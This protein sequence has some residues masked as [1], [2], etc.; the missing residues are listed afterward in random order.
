MWASWTQYLST[1]HVLLP[2][3]INQHYLGIA[4]GLP[5]YD[6][7]ARA[8]RVSLCPSTA[9]MTSRARR[10]HGST[11]A[12][13]QCVQRLNPR[14]AAC[15]CCRMLGLEQRAHE[16]V[17]GKLLPR[18]DVTVSPTYLSVTDVLSRRH[19]APTA[20]LLSMTTTA[21]FVQTWKIDRLIDISSVIRLRSQ[22]LVHTSCIRCW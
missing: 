8:D 6:E 12:Y 14:V 19:F 4:A 16:Y 9:P 15:C 2:S 17:L 18:R 7:K 10:R 1:K 22:R 21:W 5:V 3:Y 11:P 20:V 13:L